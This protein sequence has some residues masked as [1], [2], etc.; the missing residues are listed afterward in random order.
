[1]LA[2]LFG[3]FF[4]IIGVLLLARRRYFE[5]IAKG[6]AKQDLL[7]YF[8]GLLNLIL[9]LLLVLNHNVWQDSWRIVIS[10]VGWLVLLKGLFILFFSEIVAKLLKWICKYNNYFY[11]AGAIAI[12]LGL[13]FLYQG[14]WI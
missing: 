7:L 8:A 4:F 12:L 14:F 6:F 1:L 3:L 13:Y 2:K 5:A 9:G 11:F 10:V